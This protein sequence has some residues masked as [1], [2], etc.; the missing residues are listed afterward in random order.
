[1]DS[2]EVIDTWIINFDGLFLFEYVLSDAWIIYVEF[3]VD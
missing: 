1:M 3:F 2:V